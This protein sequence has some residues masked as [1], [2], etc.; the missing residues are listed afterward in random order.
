SDEHDCPKDSRGQV[1]QIVVAHN[2]MHSYRCGKPNHTR[3]T[4]Y[5]PEISRGPGTPHAEEHRDSRRTNRAA[6][7]GAVVSNQRYQA[8][9]YRLQIR[10]RKAHEGEILWH[11]HS[12]HA[13]C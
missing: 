12:R 7:A 8:R 1:K 3:E 5:L 10:P 2:R 9:T 13:K 11:K 6:K 4:Q